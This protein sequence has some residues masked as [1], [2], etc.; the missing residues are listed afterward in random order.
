MQKAI[1]HNISENQREM[2]INE[3]GAKVRRNN[4]IYVYR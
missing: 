2:L 3:K 1:S 4:I